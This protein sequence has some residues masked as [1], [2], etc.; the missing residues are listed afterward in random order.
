MKKAKKIGNASSKVRG[1]IITL[2]FAEARG[3]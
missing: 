2:L 1:R 3:Q